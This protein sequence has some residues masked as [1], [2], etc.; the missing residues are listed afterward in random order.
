VIAWGCLL[1]AVLLPLAALTAHRWLQGAI[2][3]VGLGAM[4]SLVR[5]MGTHLFAS[6]DTTAGAASISKSRH[7]R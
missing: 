6:T 2:V 4:A 1:L 3:A 7:T 5:R